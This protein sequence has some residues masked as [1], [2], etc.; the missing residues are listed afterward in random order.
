[1]SISENNDDREIK[2]SGTAAK[3][4]R[5]LPVVYSRID[6]TLNIYLVNAPFPT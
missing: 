2:K 4:E 1:M 3:E 5:Q 6:Q